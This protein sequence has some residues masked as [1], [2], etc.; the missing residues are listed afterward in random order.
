MWDKR[1][2]TKDQKFYEDKGENPKHIKYDDL[3]DLL[4]KQMPY[5]DAE[6]LVDDLKDNHGVTQITQVKMS[7]N[8]DKQLSDYVLDNLHMV[9]NIS[10]KGACIGTD[11]DPPLYIS[12]GEFKQLLSDVFRQEY[13][14]C[15]ACGQEFVISPDNEGYKIELTKMPESLL[16]RVKGTNK[17]ELE[18]DPLFYYFQD[19]S[20]YCVRLKPV[21]PN[22]LLKAIHEHYGKADIHDVVL[23]GNNEK[24]R[25]TSIDLMVKA[26]ENEWKSLAKEMD[27]FKTDQEPK[28][29]V[30]SP[31]HD[32][33]EASTSNPEQ[34]SPPIGDVDH[35]DS[36]NKREEPSSKIEGQETASLNEVRNNK[37]IP[38]M[39]T[40]EKPEKPTDIEEIDTLGHE[41][42]IIEF[43]AKEVERKLKGSFK[44][45]LNQKFGSDGWLKKK[46]SEIDNTAEALEFTERTFHLS[47]GDLRI[48]FLNQI[49]F[50]HAEIHFQKEGTHW[51]LEKITPE[52][53]G[54]TSQ[55]KRNEEKIKNLEKDIE[56]LNNKHKEQNDQLSILNKVLSTLELQ[57]P[58]EL[59]NKVVQMIDEIEDGKA[60]KKVLNMLG[61]DINAAED[62]VKQLSRLLQE[63]ISTLA[64]ADLTSKVTDLLGAWQMYQ[65]IIKLKHFDRK[66]IESLIKVFP[67][68]VQ[69]IT[70]KQERLADMVT[71]IGEVAIVRESII[72]TIAHSEHRKD[73]DLDFAKIDAE[74]KPYSLKVDLPE[75][76]NPVDPVR[77]KFVGYDSGGS[78]GTV[79]SILS[80]GLIETD[81]EGSYSRTIHK[82]ELRIYQ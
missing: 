67:S 53:I 81:A 51:R 19:L 45:N 5:I 10:N 35:N 40:T 79:S 70:A 11:Q 6:K 73:M 30:Q 58:E 39:D 44:L 16:I 62:K 43:S 78:R 9:F 61:P 68:I 66:P 64:I 56:D 24:Y 2:L 57:K 13:R 33:L 15:Y 75:I 8:G 22:D 77:H 3:K 18:P 41:K 82:P 63:H 17:D 49:V 29:E 32:T 25:L 59:Q 14:D 38:V 31:I 71:D 50:P 65:P 47:S 48:Q 76:G 21:N 26:K 12:K 37:A 55:N 72:S 27:I 28:A 7:N 54:E 74:L 1:I 23:E 20:Q 4:S 34:E 69:A 80:W 46:L 60:N 36:P 42:Y 52:F